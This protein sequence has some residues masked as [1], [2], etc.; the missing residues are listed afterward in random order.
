MK[1]DREHSHASDDYTRIQLRIPSQL[2]E[3]M[4]IGILCLA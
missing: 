2:A 3:Y 4:N 1:S